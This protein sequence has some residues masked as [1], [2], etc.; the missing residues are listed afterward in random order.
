MHGKGRGT[1]P[2]RIVCLNG[3][4][5]RKASIEYLSASLHEQA[6][7]LWKAGERMSDSGKC[8]YSRSMLGLEG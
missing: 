7:P 1:R 8:P 6:H 4:V 2:N 5:G 3:V